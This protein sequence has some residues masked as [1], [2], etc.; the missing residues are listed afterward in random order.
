MKPLIEILDRLS[1]KGTFV[2]ECDYKNPPKD[3]K[4]DYNDLV[5]KYPAI[6]KLTDYKDFLLVTGGAGY[7][8][9]TVDMMFYGFSGYTVASFDEGNFLDKDR[10]FLFGELLY[11]KDENKESEQRDIFLVFD[12][13]SDSD[14]V[15][16]GH[17]GEDYH[18]FAGSF[19]E[20]LQNI[21]DGKY[22][23]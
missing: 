3:L 14:A 18:K 17:M 2:S 23:K 9:K 15:Y 10:Y 20:F 13:K 5:K 4:D 21:A 8:D 12:T 16:F 6:A 7:E 19:S 11:I 22:P 1:S